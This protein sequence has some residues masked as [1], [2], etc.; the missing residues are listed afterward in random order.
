MTGPDYN[1]NFGNE[2][3]TCTHTGV[4]ICHYCN[5]CNYRNYY[6]INDLVIATYYSI[7]NLDSTAVTSLAGCCYRFTYRVSIGF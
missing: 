6:I 1:H 4:S 5:Y 7:Y 3:M 2:R